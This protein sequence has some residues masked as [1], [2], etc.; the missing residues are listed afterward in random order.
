MPGGLSLHIFINRK[1][2]K[3][4]SINDLQSKKMIDSLATKIEA[5]CAKIQQHFA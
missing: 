4:G 2:R 1:L 3:W 5:Q